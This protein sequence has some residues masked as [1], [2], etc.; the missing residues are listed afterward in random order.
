M[1]GTPLS[2]CQKRIRPFLRLKNQTSCDN[3]F[4]IN[5]SHTGAISGNDTDPFTRVT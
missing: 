2:S 1:R 4:P 3:W 5:E